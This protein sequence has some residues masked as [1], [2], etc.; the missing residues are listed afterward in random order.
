MPIISRTLAVFLCAACATVAWSQ[1]ARTRLDLREGQ[2]TAVP[3]TDLTIRVVKVTDFTSHGCEGGPRGCPDH[4]DLNVSRGKNQQTASLY[5]AHTGAQLERGANKKNVFGY[6]IILTVI[7][8]K[9]VT[10][11]V[12]RA[13]DVREVPQKQQ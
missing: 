10:L 3:G 5:A 7:R 6:D 11:I 1:T 9:T 13:P 4:V 12:E 8:E 2:T